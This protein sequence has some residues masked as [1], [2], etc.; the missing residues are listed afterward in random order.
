MD[1]SQVQTLFRQAVANIEAYRRAIKTGGDKA[2]L[3]LI[4]RHN[5]TVF[6]P[7]EPEG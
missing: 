7:L 5:K 2:M 1:A 3:L 4:R 6:V